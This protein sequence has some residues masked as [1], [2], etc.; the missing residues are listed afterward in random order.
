M[1]RWLTGAAVLDCVLATLILAGCGDDEEAASP[2]ADPS[3]SASAGPTRASTNAPTAA[4]TATA[5][6]ESDGEDG[7]RTFAVQIE[8]ALDAQDAAFF[9]DRGLEDEVTCGDPQEFGPCVNQPV[10]TVLRG[11][12]WVIAQSDGFGLYT[13]EQ[14]QDAIVDWF[15]KA[16]P[17][18]E[19]GYGGGALALYAIAYRRS[20][21]FE[22]EA[23][24]A[25]LTEIWSSESEANREAR[26]LSF[27]FVEDRWRLTQD[28]RAGIELTARPYLTGDCCPDLWERWEG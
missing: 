13:V 26:V 7:F 10:G 1:T 22:D 23:Y 24:Q 14:F 2:T 28:L 20:N 12:P 16:Q 27:R 17:D 25:I 19:D 21:D 5:Q 8:Q 9:A 15:G 18:L 4:A 6:A 3:P 11:I